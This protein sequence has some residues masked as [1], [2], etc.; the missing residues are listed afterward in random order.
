VNASGAKKK[1]V[2]E[3]LRQYG[4]RVKQGDISDIKTPRHNYTNLEADISCAYTV[5]KM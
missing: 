1:V 2:G 5:S 4:V 3:V